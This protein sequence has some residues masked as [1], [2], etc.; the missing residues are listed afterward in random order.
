MGML[1]ILL[2]EPWPL[3]CLARIQ[4]SSR[5]AGTLVTGHYNETDG[6]PEQLTATTSVPHLADLNSDWHLVRGSV[7]LSNRWWRVLLIC[8]PVAHMHVAG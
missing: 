2:P 6:K 8:Y 7:L 5:R 4:I 3:L 1:R